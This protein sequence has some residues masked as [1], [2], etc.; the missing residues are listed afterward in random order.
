MGYEVDV[1]WLPGAE[2]H[3][4]GKR[5]KDW[6]DGDTIFIYVKDSEEAL[7]LV[8][9]GFAHWMMSKHSKPWKTLANKLIEALEDLQHDAAEP[10]ADAIAKLLEDK[11]D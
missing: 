5:L 8:R 6:V 11:E 2:R 9:N 4:R 1:K 7:E 10:I 3:R